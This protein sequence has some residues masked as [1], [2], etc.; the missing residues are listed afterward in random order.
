MKLAAE[1]ATTLIDLN[2][3]PLKKLARSDCPRFRKWF[4]RK[5]RLRISSSPCPCSKP[6]PSP[7]LPDH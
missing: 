2:T 3:A 7:A 1:F 6:I 4:C 5:S